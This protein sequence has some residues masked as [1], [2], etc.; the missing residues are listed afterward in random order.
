[1]WRI[2]VR[3]Y[4]IRSRDYKPGDPE[5]RR[6]HKRI[7]K[8]KLTSVWVYSSP[9]PETHDSNRLLYYVLLNTKAFNIYYVMLF[10][11]LMLRWLLVQ[12]TLC[13]P[14]AICSL[15][16][17]SQGPVFPSSKVPMLLKLKEPKKHRTIGTILPSSRVLCSRALCSQV[18][19]LSV[20]KALGLRVETFSLQSKL[21]YLTS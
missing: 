12:C 10:S 1:M 11:W 16:P 13:V 3:Q 4:S 19:W 9:K 14:R 15:G 21:I 7:D 17:S 8:K 2:Q 20:S 6:T 5:N 18:L